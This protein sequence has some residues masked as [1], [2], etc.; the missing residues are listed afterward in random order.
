MISCNGRVVTMK[1]R[2]IEPHAIAA[3]SGRDE[4]NIS[5]TWKKGLNRVDTR[6]ILTTILSNSGLSPVLD[7]AKSCIA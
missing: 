4:T 3:Y 5:M 6:S 2:R 1:M 7:A